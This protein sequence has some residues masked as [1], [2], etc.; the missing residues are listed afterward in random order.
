MSAPLRDRA[1]AL[2]VVG[3]LLLGSALLTVA[4]SV[5]PGG[6][7]LE[8]DH[9]GFDLRDNYLCDLLRETAL[10][11]QPNPSVP[12]ARASLVVFAAGLIPF[13]LLVPS[14]FPD[15]AARG[16][17]VRATGVASAIGLTAVSLT[18]SD[19]FAV[20]HAVLVLT[21]IVPGVV[22]AA[23]AVRELA[24]RQDH[25]GLALLGAGALVCAAADGALYFLLLATNDTSLEIVVPLLQKP[26]VVFLIA[27]MLCTSA[28]AMR[29]RHLQA[30]W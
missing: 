20:G 8:P 1:C 14:S 3:S 4:I 21:A 16:R 7:A 6:S 17:L 18:P 22:A 15:R 28:G 26:A 30:T 10:R 23:V 13:F 11:G 24:R 25:R 9:Q 2:A 12:L 27:W 5:Y 29:V 19:R